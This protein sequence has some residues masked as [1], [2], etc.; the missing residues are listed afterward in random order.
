[1]D[2]C[3]LFLDLDGARGLDLVLDG[4]QLTVSTQEGFPFQ[5]RHLHDA[6]RRHLGIHDHP[7]TQ[8]FDL[9][10]TEEEQDLP[11]LLPS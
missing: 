3:F 5:P 11:I 10:L 4:D 9:E 6:L 8:Q 2:E 1:M 7:I